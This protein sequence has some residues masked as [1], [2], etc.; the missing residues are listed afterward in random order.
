MGR[1]TVSAPSL[2]RVCA[3]ACVNASISRPRDEVDAMRLTTARRRFGWRRTPPSK[4]VIE[5]AAAATAPARVGAVGADGGR[6]GVGRLLSVAT[7]VVS[8]DRVLDSG[9][10]IREPIAI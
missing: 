1:G 4:A 3:L 6:L 2:A 5:S 10:A 8:A 9:E 7:D